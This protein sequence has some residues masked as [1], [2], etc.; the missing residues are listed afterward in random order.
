MS[1]TRSTSPFGKL[2]FVLVLLTLLIAPMAAQA[3]PP[4]PDYTVNSLSDAADNNAG[5][6]LCATAE[7]VCTLRAAIE[8]A[9]ATAGAQTIE[10]DL[11][12]GAPYEIGLTGALP[13]IN[14]TITLTG[15]GQDLLTV[16]RVS[17]GNYGIFTV[18]GTGVFTISG[19]T[20][21]D[22]LAPLFGG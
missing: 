19:M 4:L 17:G 14:T 5:D 12:G 3:G 13:A 1:A 21:R 9:E 8:E 20:L 2:V 7:G 10:F 22:G 6:N 11:P 16:R 18:N 15:L